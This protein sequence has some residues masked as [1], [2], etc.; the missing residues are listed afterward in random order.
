MAFVQ[1]MATME[2]VKLAV[3]PFLFAFGLLEALAQVGMEFTFNG[4]EKLDQPDLQALRI[5]RRTNPEG[6]EYLVKADSVLGEYRKK[7]AWPKIQMIKEMTAY[8]RS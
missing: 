7:T 8:W 6:Y 2:N 1:L 3:I 5:I 4:R